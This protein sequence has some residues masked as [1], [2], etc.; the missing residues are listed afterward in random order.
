MA[1]AALVVHVACIRPDVP[2]VRPGAGAERSGAEPE[3][4][5]GLAVGAASA[6]LA[7]DAGIVVTGESGV[8]LGQIPAGSAATVVPGASG[9]VV[10][11]AGDMIL[12][13]ERSLTF[14]PASSEGN[15]RVN[16]RPF[17]GVAVARLDRSGLTVINRVP[18]E[19]YL[20]S[21]VP[22]EMGALDGSDDQALAAQAVVSRTYALRNANRWRPLGF[23]AYATAA[24]QVYIGVSS[25]VPAATRAVRAT[26][27]RIVTWH[28]A[29]IDAFFYSTCG[30]RTAE[31]TEVFTGASRPYLRSFADVDKSGQAWCRLSPRFRW[32][33]EWSVDLLTVTLRRTLP[34][35]GAGAAPAGD[36][37]G[38]RVAGVTASGRVAAIVVSF[39][40]REVTVAGP[41]VR[42]ALKPA[43]LD[44]LRSSAFTLTEFRTD[45]RLTR[46]IADGAGAGHGV[47]LCQ[48]GAV[49]RGRAGQ[50]FQ[51][52]LAAYFPGTDLERRY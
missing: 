13:P 24:D 7:A 21:T 25:E 49:G 51:Q 40:G 19:S 14:S 43:L 8:V 44:Q 38:V 48:W 50:S 35:A 45:G 23:D 16:G 22:A 12:G 26:R 31:G 46:L 11:G 18:L 34:A 4:R 9:V 42:R 30:G 2:G 39:G 15:I 5:I 27:G 47:G 17:R 32:R 28:G 41:A 10:Q 20:R 3:I 1:A 29:P 6:T 36:V 52:I 37:T 33:E